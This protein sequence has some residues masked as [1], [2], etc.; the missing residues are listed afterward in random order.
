MNVGL[1]SDR[2]YGV[3][4]TGS[5][6]HVVDYEIEHTEQFKYYPPGSVWARSKCGSVLVSFDVSAIAKK[7]IADP[8]R[9]AQ[10]DRS[11]R[12][13]VPPETIAAAVEDL[14]DMARALAG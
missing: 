4:Q 8:L 9:C 10:C 14:L 11:G 3:T 5:Q 2:A 13:P 1:L 12:P 7:G 6:I